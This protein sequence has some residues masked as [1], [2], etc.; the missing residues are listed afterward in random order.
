MGRTGNRRRLRQSRTWGNRFTQTV[1]E[2]GAHGRPKS[3]PIPRDGDPM[4]AQLVTCPRC[5]RDIN[6]KG[7]AKHAH[8]KHVKGER[9]EI[10]GC[11]LAALAMDPQGVLR[12]SQHPE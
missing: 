4:Q 7:L 2:Y 9:C 1:K 10:P 11:H 12:C 3:H 5:G 8:S 6:T